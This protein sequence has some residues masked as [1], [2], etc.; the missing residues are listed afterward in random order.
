MTHAALPVISRYSWAVL[1]LVTR[2]HN[3]NRKETDQNALEVFLMGTMFV[4]AVW[5]LKSC[6]QF[7]CM[8]E[9]IQKTLTKSVSHQNFDSIQILF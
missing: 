9:I 7:A 8:M 6:N 2:F 3:L 4:V 5:L 1:V